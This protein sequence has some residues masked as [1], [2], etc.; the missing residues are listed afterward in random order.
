MALQSLRNGGAEV[1][2][3]SVGLFGRMVSTRERLDRVLEVD[4]NLLTAAELE[5]LRPDA[6]AIIFEDK[7]GE[8]TKVH[9]AWIRTRSGRPVFDAAFTGASIYLI[10]DPRDVAVSWSRFVGW[11]PERS[12]DFLCDM[13]AVLADSRAG[14]MPQV[15]QPLLS[16]SRHAGSW[17]DDSGL[18]PLVVRYED[19]LVDQ[20]GALRR[21]AA[22]VQWDA[23]EDVIA[24]AVETTRF[25]LLAAKERREGFTEKAPRA[26]RFFHTGKSGTWRDVLGAGQAARLEA[27]H[28]EMMLRFGYL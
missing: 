27:A 6:H 19:M 28:R 15:V 22:H 24:R 2:F 5:E 21:M 18:N 9:D 14:I 16:W 8:L 23:P 25:E 4:S 26:P 11:T 12:V 3:T 7:E 13:E 20:A 10:R 1:D 17:I